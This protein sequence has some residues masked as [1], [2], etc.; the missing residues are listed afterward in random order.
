MGRDGAKLESG[1]SSTKKGLQ[2]DDNRIHIHIHMTPYDFASCLAHGRLDA[3]SSGSQIP[4]YSRENDCGATVG[5]PFI[6]M[7]AAADASPTL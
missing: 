7:I 1:K 2:G 5:Y 3:T 4:R 6:S